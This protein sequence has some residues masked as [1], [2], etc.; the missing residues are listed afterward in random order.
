MPRRHGAR[1]HLLLDR[2][3]P[4]TR[5]LVAQQRHRS[6]FTGTM[7]IETGNPRLLY[8]RFFLLEKI[9]QMRL[10]APAQVDL[11]SFRHDHISLKIPRRITK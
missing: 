4:R 1:D 8:T 11:L 7:A 2:L 3:A 10:D 9:F 6:D 5:V